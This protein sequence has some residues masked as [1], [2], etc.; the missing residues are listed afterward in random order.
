MGLI[1]LGV[2]ALLSGLALI[3]LEEGPERLLGWVLLPLSGAA[4]ALRG[5]LSGQDLAQASRM[6]TLRGL[7]FWIVALAFSAIALAV[8]WTFFA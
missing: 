1:V 5:A 2:L 4:L 6:L 3:V 7:V 8:A